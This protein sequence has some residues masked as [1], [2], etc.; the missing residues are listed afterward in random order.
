[1]LTKLTRRVAYFLFPLIVGI[2][3][4]SHQLFQSHEMLPDIDANVTS[5]NK[6]LTGFL[7]NE[8]N[9]AHIK[10]RKVND[11]DKFNVWALGSSRVLAF[12]EET[13][14][15]SFYNLGY[16]VSRI[17]DFELLMSKVATDKLPNY[18]ILG[19]DQWAFNTD[20]DNE[21][22]GSISETWTEYDEYPNYS[23]YKSLA[24]MVLKGIYSPKWGFRK[25]GTRYGLNAIV[26]ET[27]FRKDGSI[28]YGSVTSR[29]LLETEVQSEIFL[30]TYKRIEAGNRKFQY[31]EKVD[32]VILQD[33]ASFLDFCKNNDIQVVGFLP[34]FADR[35]YE[36]I[37]KT[38]KY[39]YML[40]LPIKLAELFND[41]GYE[42][43][44]FPHVGIIDS[45][46]AEVIDGF[47]GG[48]VSYGKMLVSML[49]S[50]SALKNV[51]LV[52]SLKYYLKNPV[53]RYT[54]FQ[55]E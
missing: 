24:S 1:M 21:A 8:S 29:L 31:G 18:L 12:R 32:D 30:D 13:F 53:N 16:T 4:L 19:L 22:N 52:D 28:Y 55:Y 34:P 35:I 43:Y 51:I 20:W 42:F 36:A 27:G 5:K 7:F 44:N 6:T 48:E 50:G 9:I 33:L 49:E 39:Q 15:T 47:H 25:D 41:Y 3:F 37:V 45:S 46:D 10:W 38:G 11:L 14:N 54:L 2:V 23:S 26:N 40:D 17:A